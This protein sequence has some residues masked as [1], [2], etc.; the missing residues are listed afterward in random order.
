MRKKNKIVISAFP[1][2]GKSYYCSNGDWSQYVS[3]GFCCDSDSSLFDKSDFPNNYMTHIKNRID[4]NYYRIFV[5]SHKEVR[6]ALIDNKIEFTLVY[7]SIDLKEEYIARYKDRGS[8]DSFIDLVSSN[9][10][11]WINECVN[12]KGCEHIV[13]KSGEYLSNVI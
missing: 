8:S 5:S 12:Q 11:A 1:A 13:L 9:W 2:T 4:E 6:E 3:D 7:P 10:D